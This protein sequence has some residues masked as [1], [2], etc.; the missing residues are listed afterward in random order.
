MQGVNV[1]TRQSSKYNSNKV[2]KKQQQQRQVT[3]KPAFP[4][5]AETKTEGHTQLN[6]IETST[7][8]VYKTRASKT[9]QITIPNEKTLLFVGFR[10]LFFFKPTTNKIKGILSFDCCCFFLIANVLFQ[11]NMREEFQKKIHT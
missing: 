7:N 5:Q 6:I 10:F 2:I 4:A 1:F 3:K 9:A 11:P 8:L